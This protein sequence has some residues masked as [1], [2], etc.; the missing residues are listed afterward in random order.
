MS[1]ESRTAVIVLT[2]CNNG[3]SNP[4]ISAQYIANGIAY[5]MDTG[6]T[7][8]PRTLNHNEK[9]INFA[10]LAVILVLLG[11]RVFWVRWFRR[12]LVM[13]KAKRLFSLATYITVDGL[14]PLFFLVVVPLL[15]DN[16]WEYLLNSNPQL[17]FQVA[18][19]SLVLAGVF[20]AKTVML[21]SKAGKKATT[22]LS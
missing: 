3:F 1:P 12:D 22:V 16:T 4:P 5:I 14:I 10:I 7:P 19:S 18:L 13:S 21:F 9:L 20:A 2:N 15:I 11:L 17:W 8:S 6:N